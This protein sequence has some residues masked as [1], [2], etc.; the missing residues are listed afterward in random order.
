MTCVRLDH[1][2]CVVQAG[3]RSTRMGFD[4]A[5]ASFLGEPL[6][7]RVLRLAAPAA[8]ELAVTSVRPQELFFLEGASFDGL[9][10]RVVADLAGPAG[11]MR[12]IASSL[13]AASAPLVAVVACDMPFVSPDLL[14]ALAARLER[15]GLDVCVPRVARGIEPLCAVWRRDTCLPVA[16]ELLAQDAQRIRLLIDRVN[17]GYL[18]ES[19]IVAAAGSLDCFENVNTPDELA[20][21]QE[22]AVGSL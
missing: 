21:V 11:A 12:G 6:V 5:T 1:L 18:D 4:K 8:S 13:A 15:D 14:C 9:P 7:A 19:A 3:G 20:A 22:R 2:A 10:V 17:A 16:R